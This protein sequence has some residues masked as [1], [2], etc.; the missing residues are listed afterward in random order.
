[1]TRGLL[2]VNFDRHGK[3]LATLLQQFVPH[4]HQTFRATWLR[5]R[6]VICD[7]TCV[8]IIVVGADHKL[9]LKACTMRIGNENVGKT[10][11]PQLCGT[12]AFKRRCATRAGLLLAAD[13]RRAITIK[14]KRKDVAANLNDSVGVFA[15]VPQVPRVLFPVDLLISDKLPML[16]K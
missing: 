9:R 11:V 16:Y 4:L 12:D 7:A 3:E 15:R 14:R 8:G 13:G 2:N 5:H 1:M 10:I 6:S